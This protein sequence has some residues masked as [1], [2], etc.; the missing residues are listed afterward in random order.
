[1]LDD[2]NYMRPVEWQPWYQRMP[3][4]GW[5]VLAN[6][7]VFAAQLIIPQ[8]ASRGS[9]P[10][11]IEN[12]LALFPSDLEKG[13]IWQLFTF[14]FLHAGPMHLILNSAMLFIFGRPLEQ[15]LGGRRFLVL[16]FGSGAFGGLF[17]AA[18][19]LALP[20]FFGTDAT[21]GASAG[22]FGLIAAFATMY[23]DQ[24]ITTLVAF[25]I[26]VSMRAKYLLV[27]E[28]IIA[29]LGML[30]R[31]SNVAHAAHM[32]GMIGGILFIR[33]A[34]HWQWR[35]QWPGRRRTVAT[36]RSPRTFVSVNYQHSLPKAHEESE[37]QSKADELSAD[38]FLAR[39]VDPILDKISASGI[40][41]LTARERRI[42][43][44]A[45]NKIRRG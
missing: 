44:S 6:V 26:P 2:R 34:V 33:K 25:V 22:V 17:Q 15:A 5:L 10:V 27:A 13:Y 9:R 30:D 40:H 45:R 16:Y 12:Y 11:Y 32:G 29:F 18:C 14:Q 7:V 1:M 4:A 24:M 35:F 37:S 39:E 3:L 28:F 19:S 31:T 21:V 38:E 8:M 20:G 23:A 41:S 42:L 36:I 43:E